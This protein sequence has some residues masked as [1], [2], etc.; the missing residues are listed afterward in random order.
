MRKRVIGKLKGKIGGIA[1][2]SESASSMK[3][4]EDTITNEKLTG[5]MGEAG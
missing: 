2:V 5:T 3:Q 1:R 4:T